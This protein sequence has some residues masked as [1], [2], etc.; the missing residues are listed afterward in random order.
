VTSDGDFPSKRRSLP[1]RFSRIVLLVALVLPRLAILIVDEDAFASDPDAYRVLAEGWAEQGIFGRG[2][3]AGDVQPTAYRSPAYPWLIS[4][5]L[6][7]DLPFK[8]SMAVFH[9]GLGIATGLLVFRIGQR[10]SKTLDANHVDGFQEPISIWPMIAAGAVACDP[11]LLRQSTL[12]MTETLATFSVVL[13]WWLWLCGNDR[14]FL[15]SMKHQSFKAG[16]W[17]CCLGMAFGF[18]IL[19]RPNFIPWIAVL[20]TAW[21]AWTYRFQKPSRFPM[22]GKYLWMVFGC[23]VVLVPW[24]S[25]NVRELGSPIW[26]TTHGGYTLLLANNPILYDHYR[27]GSWSRS[28]KEDEFHEW[29]S[30]KLRTQ[31]PNEVALDQIAQ[32]EAWRTMTGDPVI[33]LKSCISRWAWLW[34]WWPGELLPTAFKSVIGLWYG[35]TLTG[36]A[37]LAFFSF[38]AF[39]RCPND[40]RII[41]WLPALALI[42]TVMLTHTF[43]WSN[44]RMRAPLMPIIYLALALH[45]QRIANSRRWI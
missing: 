41:W 43:Y 11:I 19:V 33:F 21:L 10:L 32:R 23:L 45:G 38:W 39:L 17:S 35:V 36:F 1:W 18:A 24:V 40:S 26:T 13:I 5:V 9:L 8:L 31:A 14:N 27:S 22:I 12:V 37:C 6:Y 30:E 4:W 2:D 42:V 20:G 34:A 15:N 29:W 25:R 28:W 3:V 16:A 7:F 44:M